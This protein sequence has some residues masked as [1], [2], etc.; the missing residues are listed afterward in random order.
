MKKKEFNLI[1]FLGFLG[2]LGLLHKDLY[3]L[4]FLFFLFFLGFI[5]RKEKENSKEKEVDSPGALFIPAGVLT[6]MGVG[7]LTGSMP[8]SMFTGLGL[9]FALFALHEIFRKK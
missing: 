2:F 3:F 6:G 9:G 1:G 7:F 4:Q 8:G 5:H